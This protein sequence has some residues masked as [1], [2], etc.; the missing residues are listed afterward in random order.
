MQ[1]YSLR[2]CIKL[3]VYLIKCKSSNV[4]H[5]LEKRSTGILKLLSPNKAYA[6]KG[7]KTHTARIFLISI[8]YV[9]CMQHSGLGYQKNRIQMWDLV[10]RM[11]NKEFD[12]VHSSTNR[13]FRIP[14]SQSLALCIEWYA[15]IWG[16]K[17][18]ST[19]S[20]SWCSRV[21]HAN[22]FTTCPPKKV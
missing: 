14:D 22:G 20:L 5:S 4:T 16:K 2:V 19:D 21:L 13:I 8:P 9:F 11:S 3:K 1:C 12:T 18:N 17:F 15:C 7:V 6:L 10:F